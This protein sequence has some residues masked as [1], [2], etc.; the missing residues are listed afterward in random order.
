L[1]GLIDRHAPSAVLSLGEARGTLHVR[2]ETR[3]VNRLAFQSDNSGAPAVDGPVIAG[4]AEEYAS[5]FPAEA[6]VTALSA[7]GIEA[8]MSRSAGTYC[9]NQ[10]LYHALHHAATRRPGMSVGFLHLPSLSEQ[11]VNG[12]KVDYG[13]PLDVQVRAVRV[14]L[15]ELARALAVSTAGRLRLS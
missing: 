13:M 11:R 6:I 4:G 3:A 2:V 8:A 1:G 10:V 9:C 15:G 7:A 14:A 12:A 5:T